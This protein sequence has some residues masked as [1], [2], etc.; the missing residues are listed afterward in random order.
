M[1]AQRSPDDRVTKNVKHLWAEL[2]ALRLMR[3]RTHPP[4]SRDTTILDGGTKLGPFWSDCKRKK[5]CTRPPYDRLLANPVLRA[6][7]RYPPSVTRGSWRPP[8][9]QREALS[10]QTTRPAA[11]SGMGGDSGRRAWRGMRLSGTHPN[12]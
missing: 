3:D 9:A 1:I 8:S 4:R 6:D 12:P 10:S 2:P 5:R 11:T 7:Y